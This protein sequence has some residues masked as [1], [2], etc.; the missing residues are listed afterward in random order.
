MSIFLHY[1]RVALDAEYDNSGKVA[2]AEDYIAGWKTRSEEA[3][4]N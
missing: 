2:D 4:S 1:D 3:R